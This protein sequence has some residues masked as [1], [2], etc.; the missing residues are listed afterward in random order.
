MRQVAYLNRGIKIIVEDTR[1]P[2]VVREEFCYKGGIKEYVLF[3]NNH[4]TK[5]FDDVIYCEGTAPITLASGNE[6]HV[7]AEIAMQYD[8][9]FRNV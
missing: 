9:T 7:Y 1:N 2:E 5:L 8:E 3:I 6:A 4:K